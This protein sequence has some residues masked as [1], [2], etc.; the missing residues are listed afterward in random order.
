LE[1]EVLL[2]KII[3]GDSRAVGLQG[4]QI[5]DLSESKIGGVIP[6]IRKG[7]KIIGIVLGV[8]VLLFILIGPAAPLWERMGAK[9][10]CIQGA[11]PHLKVVSCEGNNA[12]SPTV[13]PL[14]LPSLNGQAP[15]PLI[16]DDDGSPD[17]TIALLYFLNNPLFD[18]RAVTISSGE[19]HPDIF[20][21]HILQLLAGLGKAGIPVGAGRATPLEGN[22]AFPEPWRQVSDNFWD[23]KLPAATNELKPIPAADLIVKTIN[24]TEQ[25]ALVFVS[26]TH[27]NLADA[28]RI[29]PGIA[30][31]IRG[32]YI[33][34]GSI[35]GQGNIKSDWPSIDNSVAE[36]NIWVDPVAAEEVFSSG[37]P[38]H[39]IPLDATQK[40]TWTPSDLSGWKSF[41]SPE[42]TM[43]GNLLQWMLDSWSP[44]GVY[45][46]DLV[47]AVQAT[48]PAICPEVSL[49]V[50]IVTTSGPEQGRTA[51]IR[52]DPNVAV[53]LNPDSGQIKAI[54]A[55]ILGP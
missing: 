1:R 32:V 43:A 5:L 52:G 34:G 8:L 51:I 37:L 10:V 6:M 20:A 44:A 46:W 12:V 16:V 35:S 42:G 11:F 13:T 2:E 47:A 18:V 23:I 24:D 19:A 48:N 14:V 15:I 29:D 22:N 36:W 27:T 50:D 4:I 55:S 26:G 41:N 31:K 54:A 21:A 28:L 3:S 53:C 25:P 45:I 7:L 17:G 30:D 40:V 39:V 33:M 49:P 38:L 9:P